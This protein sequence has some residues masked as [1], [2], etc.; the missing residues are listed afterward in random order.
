MTTSFEVTHCSIA[1]YT[2]E[3]CGPFT[4]IHN[5][6]TAVNRHCAYCGNPVKLT[7]RSTLY[8]RNLHGEW[9]PVKL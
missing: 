6:W 5:S 3:E 4:V 8:E 2:C 9:L 7:C 1:D